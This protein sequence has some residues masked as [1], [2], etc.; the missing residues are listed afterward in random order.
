MVHDCCIH[1]QMYG[2]VRKSYLK[3]MYLV[4][5]EFEI[6]VYCKLR[7]EFFPIDLCPNSKGC[8]PLIDGKN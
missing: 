5:A 6:H 1:N 4:F 8:G 7:T 2:A 3:Y